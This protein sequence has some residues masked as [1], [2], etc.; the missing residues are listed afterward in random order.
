M[1]DP[2]CRSLDISSF[3]LEPMQRI[4]R[5]PL[6]I[7]QILHY[8]PKDH[9]DHK[10]LLQSLHMAEML[11]T[12]V[13]AAAKDA[14]SQEKMAEIASMVDTDNYVGPKLDLHSNTRYVGARE[15]LHEGILFKAKSGRKLYVYLFNDLLL[16]CELSRD[17]SFETK[18]QY[19]IYR[20][21]SLG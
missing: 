13:N 7:K 19:C 20:K 3:L 1:M 2:R 6:L 10:D 12:L 14:E 17:A 18:K 9:Q 15:C 8:T 16:M 4:T 5:Y 11:L 21:V